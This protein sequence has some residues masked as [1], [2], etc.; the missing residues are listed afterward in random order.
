MIRTRRRWRW[1]AF[2]GPTLRCDGD[3]QTAQSNS[4][5]PRS[6]EPTPNAFAWG[7][8]TPAEPEHDQGH[9]RPRATDRDC[10]QPQAEEHDSKHRPGGLTNPAPALPDPRGP[11]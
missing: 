11:P 1:W 8:T 10:D 3:E 7:Q 9:C 5:W 4:G 2:L 6:D